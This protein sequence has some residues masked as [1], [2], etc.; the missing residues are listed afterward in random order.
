MKLLYIDEGGDDGEKGSRFYVLG[1]L[2]V[3]V[4][5]LPQLQS[6][7]RQL[8]A[9][10]F[11]HWKRVHAPQMYM[12]QEFERDRPMPKEFEKF[13]VAK[14][15]LHYSPLISKKPPFDKLSDEQRKELADAVIGLVLKHGERL[16][17]VAI[18]KVKHSEK[19]LIPKPVDLFTIEMMAERF[20]AYLKT[21][22]DV[23]MFVYDYKDKHN[24][25]IFRNFVDFIRTDGTAH[26]KLPHIVENLMFLPSELC[27]GLQLADFVAHSLFMKFERARDQRYLELQKRFFSLK[28]FP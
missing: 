23:G 8:V 26:M 7:V 6:D 24:N 14:P 19:Y 2:V 11:R 22:D 10:T 5:A 9:K 18:D 3:D 12:K 25:L 13:G 15:E 27:E 20:E 21:V 4:K 16:L 17:G 28:E 1:G